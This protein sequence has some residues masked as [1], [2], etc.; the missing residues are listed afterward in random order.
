MNKAVARPATAADVAARAG[1]SRATVSHIFTGRGKNFA[2]ATRDRV[3]RAAAELDY[4][5]SAAGRSLVLGRG[6]TIVVLV[7]KTTIG[8]NHLDALDR[9][10]SD[11]AGIGANVVLRF[12]DDDHDTT[13]TALLHMRPLAVVDLGVA[14]P[15]SATERL[16]AQGVPL[17]IPS[18]DARDELT[19]DDGRIAEIQIDELTRNDSRQILYTIV[20]DGQPD[21]WTPSRMASL[22]KACSSRGLADPVAL[23]LP[24]HAPTA[25]AA[26]S[27]HLTSGPV[28]VAAFND[29][30]AIAV[31][32]IASRLHLRVPDDVAIVGVDATPLSQLVTPRIT[33]IDVN[34]F[35]LVD[36]AMD[37]LSEQLSLGLAFDHDQTAEPFR[38]IRGES[39]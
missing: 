20:D 15:P 22:Q 16:S 29:T 33:T 28:G 3:L 34:M 18:S 21:F 17:A 31:A 39:S 19:H 8:Q 14:L 23:R 6:D 2:E 32:N 5:P 11:T 4:R 26:L 13:V 35:S 25:D 7:P 9:L 37:R 38:L 30:A 1:V 12:A 36:A 27:R 24:H 10:A